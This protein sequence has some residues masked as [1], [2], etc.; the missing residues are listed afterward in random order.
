MS[1]WL[2]VTPTILI[3]VVVHLFASVPAC[4]SATIPAG[5][6]RQIA[7][8]FGD[9]TYV[10]AFLPAGFVY[11]SWNIEQRSPIYLGKELSIKFAMHGTLL[12]WTVRDNR[13]EDGEDSYQDPVA[14]VIDGRTITYGRGIHGDEA[15]TVIALGQGNS[16]RRIRINLW[17]ANNPGRP[18]KAT[19]LR[20]VASASR[21]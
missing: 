9:D 2:L 8:E 5:T 4:A 16:A 20:M 17:I 15:R 19:A 12:V 7:A 18:S 21:P 14:A 13:E 6:L 3:L 11:T 10:P 1:R